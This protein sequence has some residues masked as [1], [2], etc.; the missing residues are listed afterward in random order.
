MMTVVY[1]AFLLF[2]FLLVTIAPVAMVVWFEV[3]EARDKKARDERRKRY[4][5]R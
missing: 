1:E 2:V 5:A 3:E 4:D